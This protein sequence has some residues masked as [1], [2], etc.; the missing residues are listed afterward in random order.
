[1]TVDTRAPRS[2]VCIGFRCSDRRKRMGNIIS[3]GDRRV[4]IY[5]KGVSQLIRRCSASCAPTTASRVR[6]PSWSCTAGEHRL[7]WD[8]RVDGKPLDARHLRRAVA[9][10]ATRAGNVGHHARRARG[11]RRDPGPPRADRARDRRAAAAAAGH[12]RQPGRVPRRR[13]RRLLPLA[14]APGGRVGGAQARRGD[15]TRC[16]RS[17][18]PRGR[19]ARTCS[20]CA[21][22]AGARRC[23]SWSRR[24][25]ARRCSS[26][27]RRSAG[28][29]PTRSTTRRSTGCR[30]RWP[31]AGRCAG[32]ACSTATA[33]PA[34][35]VRRRRRAAARVPRPA[36]DPLRPDERSRPRA[37]A[38]PARLATATA[39]CCSARRAGS[40]ARSGGACAATS[41]TAGTWP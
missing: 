9:R 36:A 22:A 37:H 5:I 13:P 10:C 4:K 34:G 41:A 8:P 40:R 35:R 38:Q 29:G 6:S 12:R 31:T 21:P 32:R 23:R 39:C 18:R 14:R 26:S 11:R 19:R 28:W 1:M 25:S 3:Q 2:A 33:R 30:T 16:S 7:D 24:P 27:C 15:A 17:A 20:S